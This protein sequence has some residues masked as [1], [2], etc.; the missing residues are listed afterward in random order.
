M[1]GFSDPIIGGGGALVYPAVRSPGFVHGVS[2]WSI[3]KDGS[4]EFHDVILPG[5]QGV[6][7]FFASSAPVTDHVGDLWYDTADGLALSQWNGATWV[8]YQIGTGAIA[9]GAVT[10]AK[11][12]ANT[13]TA[14]Q[15][16]A[17]TITATQIAGNTI[18]AGLLAAGIVVAGI[19]NGTTI[20]GATFIGTGTSG[21]VLVYD[22]AP[23]AGNLIA[24]VSSKT[25]TDSEGNAYNDGVS[26]YGPHSGRVYIAADQTSGQPF[27]VMAPPGVTHLT[28]FPQAY[29]ASGNAGAADEYLYF[30]VTSGEDG[31][32]S[33]AAV[34]FYSDSADGTL[35]GHVDFFAGGS[36]VFS[37]SAATGSGVFQSLSLVNGWAASG[38][39]ANGLFCA[40][41]LDNRVEL[42]GD[43][44]NGTATGNSVCAVLPAGY[45]PAQPLNIGGVMWNDPGNPGPSVPWLYI[46]TSGNI[47]VTGIQAAGHGVA[48]SVRFP[49]ASL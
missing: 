25:G 34:V 7:V 29:A 31:G 8:A 43:I 13:I 27:L 33:D 36:V 21:E 10:A 35:P 41:T 4:A 44:L 49:L 48:F 39:G 23:A 47:Q 30:K 37:V 32:R 11:V 46:D 9:D 20:T 18:T 6:S 12:A 38:G 19:V 1:A 15:I 16:A 28:T 2:G 26:S 17:A 5:G 24:S 40:K 3:N 22:G 14:A 42:V 45:R